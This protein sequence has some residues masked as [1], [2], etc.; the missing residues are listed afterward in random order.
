MKAENKFKNFIYTNIKTAAKIASIDIF[1]VI[2]VSI[3]R[4]KVRKFIKTIFSVGLMNHLFPRR[5]EVINMR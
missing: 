3:C 2:V 5:E 4:I 1:L